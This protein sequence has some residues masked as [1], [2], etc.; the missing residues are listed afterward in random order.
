MR[1]LTREDLH[2]L[3]D[4]LA[5]WLDARRGEPAENDDASTPPIRGSREPALTLPNQ[6]DHSTAPV[7]PTNRGI[8]PR[9]KAYPV[10][11]TD[12]AWAAK[13]LRARGWPKP[14]PSP[15]GPKR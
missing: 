1:D 14:K 2:E 7:D 3:A 4:L 10:S 12:R 6:E 9:P 15:G 5:D 8:K 13:Q 11:E